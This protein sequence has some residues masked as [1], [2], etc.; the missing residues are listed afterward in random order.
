MK[1][2]SEGNGPALVASCVAPLVITWF[3]SFLRV[4]VRWFMLKIWKVE[5][6]LFVASQVMPRTCGTS[7]LPLNTR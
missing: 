3:F 2:I 6:W 7:R 1:Y 5:D 4:Y